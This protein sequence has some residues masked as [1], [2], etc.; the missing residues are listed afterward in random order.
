MWC[1]RIVGSCNKNQS[2]HL[3]VQKISEYPWA[4][5]NLLLLSRERSTIDMNDNPSNPHSHP[6]PAF[7]H[8]PQ[9]KAKWVKRQEREASC[10]DQWFGQEFMGFRKEN[11][12]Q[13]ACFIWILCGYVDN[14]WYYI[15]IYI[16]YIYM[17][18]C[19]C[20]SLVGIL[21]LS[22]FGKIML[23]RLSIVSACAGPWSIASLSNCLACKLQENTKLH[24]CFQD[25][26][27]I[28]YYT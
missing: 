27:W 22:I 13:L 19:V 18:V 21:R 25:A 8:I 5:K 20:L 23:Q 16:I 9:V 14:F 26:P 4:S 24:G 11:D 12:L 7:S 2:D 6:F 3:Q 17:C 10:G 1:W 15:Y 28:L